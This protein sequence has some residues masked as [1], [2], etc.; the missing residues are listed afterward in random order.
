MFIFFVSF[1]S[2][3]DLLLLLLLLDLM[4]LNEWEW[5]EVVCWRMR[6]KMNEISFENE[7][8]SW[9][10]I[11]FFSFQ[12]GREM[13]FSLVSQSIMASGTSKMGGWP[14][15]EISKMRGWRWE[16]D[17]P[18]SDLYSCLLEWI[19]FAPHD[20]KPKIISKQYECPLETKR[21]SI[22]LSKQRWRMGGRKKILRNACRIIWRSNY[23]I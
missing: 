20:S 6:M 10:S 8:T 4:I 7:Q 21:S 11:I 16:V 17:Y 19:T 1:F 9:T 23:P 12:W 18:W 2:H 13:R 15:T 14:K 22:Q 5:M 3:P